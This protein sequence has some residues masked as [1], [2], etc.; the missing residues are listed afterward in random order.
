MELRKVDKTNK[1]WFEVDVEGLKALQKGKSKTFIVR[2]LIQNAWDENIENCELNISYSNGKINV[3]VKDDSP[4]GFK[5]LRDAYTLFGDTSKRKNTSQRGRFNFGEKQLISICERAS[6]KTTKGT[7]SF[8]VS[9]REQSEE[10]TKKGTIVEIQV[11]G[12]QEDT[13]SLINYAKQLLVPKKIKFYVNGEIVKYQSP[14]KSFE[15]VLQTEVQDENF[16]KRTKRKTQVNLIKEE[17]TQLYEMGIP[18]MEID[19]GYSIDVQQKVPLSFDRDSVNQTFIK[20]LYV[21]VLNNVYNDIEE[22]S[23]SKS[24]IRLAMSGKG[25]LSEAIDKILKNRYGEKFVVANPF[26][27]NSIDEAISHGYNVIYGNEMS[28]EEWTNIKDNNLME[29]SSDLF[30]TNFTNAPIIK[31]NEKQL[32]VAELTK[33]IAKELMNI[34]ISVSFVKGGSNMVVAQYGERHLTFNVSKLNNDFF[35]IPVSQ[36]T[37][38]LILHELG[39]E[40]GNHTESSYHELITK[41]GAKLTLV[42]L[43]KPEF[44]KI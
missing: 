5:N 6:I 18:I 9:G 2:E 33:K 10:K 22:D 15:A 37:L 23:S 24:W 17:Q 43:N 26:D 36:E 42:A 7:I 30:G 12:N 38:N 11:K 16:L 44:F 4:E 31:P 27:K 41:L 35:D 29:S 40:A 19:C 32:K 13:D 28:K 1:N 39:H 14:F 20:E 34:N 3:I 21:E 8:S 25:V